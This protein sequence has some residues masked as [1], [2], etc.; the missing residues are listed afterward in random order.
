MLDVLKTN[1]WEQIVPFCYY[2]MPLR[3]KLDDV[4]KCLLDMN[5]AGPLRCKY[6]IEHNTELMDKVILMTKADRV[7]QWVGANE[8]RRD[9]LKYIYEILKIMYDSPLRSI[10]VSE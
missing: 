2:F 5:R 7:T 6:V 8:V 10:L 4:I 1:E 9:Q 3:K